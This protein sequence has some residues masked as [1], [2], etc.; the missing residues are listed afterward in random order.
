MVFNT[1]NSHVQNDTLHFINSP[2]LLPNM[3]Y[4]LSFWYIMPTNQSE[5]TINIVTSS[6]RQAIWSY[7]YTQTNGWRQ[8]KIA[9]D[10]DEEF[11]VTM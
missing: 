11:K 1:Y 7:G 9:I 3:S 10:A 6:S 8:V 5:L 2:E 4:C